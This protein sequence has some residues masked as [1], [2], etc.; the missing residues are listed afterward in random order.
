V[1]VPRHD[2]WANLGF[3]FVTFRK[4]CMLMDMNE[5]KLLQ[6]GKHTLSLWRR[7][8]F[9]ECASLMK[10]G[11]RTNQ[12]CRYSSK[13]VLEE[14]VMVEKPPVL[15]PGE[16]ETHVIAHDEVC[17]HVNDLSRTEWVAGG[18]QPLRQKGRGR[19][20][21]V[22]DFIIERTGRLCLTESEREAQTK[23]PCA[24]DV[25]PKRSVGGSV[26]TPD[27]PVKKIL[28][29]KVRKERKKK[30]TLPNKPSEPTGT[31]AKGRTFAEN[32]DWSPNAVSVTG[33]GPYRLPSFDARRIIYPGAN[34]D[35]WW[36]MPQLIAQ[37]SA[38]LHP[39]DL[40]A[41]DQQCSR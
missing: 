19:I 28:D 24:P 18:K 7:M 27:L 3:V 9:C 5:R 37:V 31:S 13:Y 6:L 16:K 32:S 14:G 30:E 26:E 12:W 21:H 22:S 2:G 33:E 4:G 41:R 25:A 20:V 36:D 34:G 40:R 1:N 23:L 11:R 35:P 17:F 8:F 38:Y 39:H 15:K 10:V 29:G